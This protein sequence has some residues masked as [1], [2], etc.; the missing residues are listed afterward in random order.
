M[1]EDTFLQSY[2]QLLIK[3][4]ISIVELG[5]WNG[6]MGMAIT[7]F[8]LFRI[9]K[10]P[11][12]EMQA[13]DLIE[14]IYGSISNSIPFHFADGLLGIGCGFEYIVGKGFVE[15]DSD[16]ILLEIDQI[17][18]NM[19]DFRPMDSLDI[20]KGVCGVGC[21]LYYRLRN[22]L[23]NDESMTT[24]KLKEYLIYLIDW[25][26]ELLLKT[27]EKTDYNDVYCLFCRFRELD[28]FN[29]KVEKLATFCLEKMLDSNCLIQD[30]YDLLGIQSLKVLKPW[31]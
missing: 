5:L 10:K 12:Y 8:H 29:Y 11:E 23:G 30:N 4:S 15:G 18:K 21:Y 26:E 9:T 16:E 3:K 14:E 27:K 6:K 24:L 17:T 28:V 31:I 25:I 13:N 22:K 1:R 2:G 20:G 7:L 19:I